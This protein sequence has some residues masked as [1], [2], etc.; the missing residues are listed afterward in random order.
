MEPDIA[1]SDLILPVASHSFK[2]W[3]NL[4]AKLR[5]HDKR[6][7]K[8]WKEEIDN[9]LVFVSLSPVEVIYRGLKTCLHRLVSSPQS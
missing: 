1:V 2:A 3:G 7:V 5:R 8:A 6:L 9:I 4:D